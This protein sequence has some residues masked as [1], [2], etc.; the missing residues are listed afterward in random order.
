MAVRDVIHSAQSIGNIH[1]KGLTSAVKIMDL[2]MLFDLCPVP[3]GP[4]EQHFL[5]VYYRQALERRDSFH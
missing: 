2:A 3:R 1:W 4:Q 5:C